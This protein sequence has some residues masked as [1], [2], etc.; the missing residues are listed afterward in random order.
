MQG[1]PAPSRRGP[2]RCSPARLTAG[3]VR[4]WAGMRRR[5]R[6]TS[7]RVDQYPS[8][9]CLCRRCP[10]SAAASWGGVRGPQS[11]AGCGAG[12]TGPHAGLVATRGRRVWPRRRP[13]RPRP[14]R[15]AAPRSRAAAPTPPDRRPGLVTRRRPCRQRIA[16][17]VAGAARRGRGRRGARDEG[18]A[19]P[20]IIE[21]I[22]KQSQHYFSL[23]YYYSTMIVH[24]SAII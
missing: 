6:L 17:A 14:T 16:R 5:L 10:K 4:L 11:C 21:I 24:N 18:A 7:I 1:L 23:F 9:Q 12:R 13:I 22:A 20:G 3:R 8:D 15:M 2:A 19:P